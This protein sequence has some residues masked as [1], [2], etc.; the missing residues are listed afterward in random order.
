MTAGLGVDEAIVDHD[1]SL[2]FF[3]TDLSPPTPGHST[4]A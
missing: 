2:V 1:N 3:L 4:I